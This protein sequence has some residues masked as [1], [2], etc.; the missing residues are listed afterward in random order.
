MVDIKQ[1]KE[2]LAQLNGT[3]KGTKSN[4]WWKPTVGDYVVRI[5]PWQDSN[6][7]PIKEIWYYYG[8]GRP[9][10]Q[11]HG[12]FPMPTL[13]QYKKPDPIQELINRL[14][15]DNPEENKELLKKLYPKMKGF[16]P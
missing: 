1:I 8:I 2:K 14:R 16:V 3:S 15:K 11:G 12:P 4:I 10:A 6:G 9:N 13:S 7:Q 5:V